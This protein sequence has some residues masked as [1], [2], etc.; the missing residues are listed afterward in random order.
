MVPE[1]KPALIGNDKPTKGSPSYKGEFEDYSNFQVQ[2][3]TGAP[4]RDMSGG[5]TEQENVEFVDETKGQ[6]L[7]TSAL[8]DASYTTA[9]QPGAS[10][11]SFLERPVK[12]WANS[13]SISAPRNADIF[14]WQL[15]FDEPSIKRKLDNYAY[16][17]CNLHIKIVISATPFLYGSMLVSYLPLPA[18]AGDNDADTFGEIPRHSQRPHIWLYPQEGGGGELTLPFFFYKDWLDAT[19]SNQFSEMGTLSFETVSDL[20]SANGVATSDVTISVYAWADN[21]NVCGPTTGLALQ[22]KNV[23]ARKLKK[24]DEYGQ[25]IISKPASAVAEV[26]R[27]LS[28]I[29]AIAPFATATQM[30]ATA[31]A[32]LS[33]LCGWSNPPVLEDVKPYK[34]LVYHSVATGSLCEPVEKMTLD[35]KAELTVDNQVTGISSVDELDIP[36]FCGRDSYLL[37]AEWTDADAEET[38]LFGARVTPMTGISQVVSNDNKY[39]GIPGAHVARM[40]ESWR[41]DMIYHF[42][43]VCSQ[44]HRGRLVFMWDPIT[45]MVGV[46]DYTSVLY[47]KII[48]IGETTEF[49]VRIPYMQDTPWKHINGSTRTFNVTDGAIDITPGENNGTVALRVL[50]ELTCPNA[51]TTV[52]IMCFVRCAENIQFADP[53]DIDPRFSQFAVQSMDTEPITLYNFGTSEI[54]KEQMLIN[55]GEDITNLRTLMRRSSRVDTLSFGSEA[56]PTATYEKFTYNMTGIP[57]PNGYDPNGVD[58]ANEVVGAGTAP[59][60][61]TRNHPMSYLSGCFVGRRGAMRWH[62]VAHDVHGPI[63]GL[64]VCRNA[65]S[66]TKEGLTTIASTTSSDPT[67]IKSAALSG[68]GSAGG[69]TVTHTSTQAGLSYETPMYTRIRFQPAKPDFATNG[70]SVGVSYG[71]ESN[72]ELQFFSIPRINSADDTMIDRYCSIGT[73][74]NFVF[75]LNTP[76][77]HYS[78]AA[79]TPA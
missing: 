6:V 44:Y 9:I 2:S 54:T 58:T 73:D 37:S 8:T 32:Q 47:H 27:A 64:Q 17:N 50:N 22:S 16:L 36:T 74:F 20:R 56:N 65:Y 79:P 77:L 10:L 43:V 59:Y 53:N 38:P 45:S 55:Y 33:S 29:P 39:Q 25:G 1:P 7:S 40:F 15:F 72:F 61:F 21:V 3:A 41:G 78:L 68:L 52:D 66:S 5:D 63:L 62:L 13:W 30:G 71:A 69:A 76:L 70:T 75:F 42:K 28:V 34:S 26:A 19:D 23:P 4:D 18:W 12:I 46:T 35:P 31:I 24:P 48:D 51:T 14:P 49:E 67:Y 11:G 60:N 57:P